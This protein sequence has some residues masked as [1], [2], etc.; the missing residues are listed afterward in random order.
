MHTLFL[1]LL[2]ELF[3]QRDNLIGTIGNFML[4]MCLTAY[5]FM[6]ENYFFL[7]YAFAGI[8]LSM[9]GGLNIKFD[10]KSQRQINNFKQLMKNRRG[11]NE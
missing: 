5:V 3:K 11:L 8:I 10:K 6:P 9:L 7:C 2:Q 1:I 4:G